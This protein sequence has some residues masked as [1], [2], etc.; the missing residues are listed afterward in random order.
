MILPGTCIAVN[1]INN[2]S[3]ILSKYRLQLIVVDSGRDEYEVLQQVVNITYHQ[4]SLNAVGITGFLSPKT[5]SVLQ[6]LARHKRMALVT[7]TEH[8]IPGDSNAFFNFELTIC[9]G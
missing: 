5:V 6:P 8:F 4:I 9:C 1:G 7:A 3:S 2:D